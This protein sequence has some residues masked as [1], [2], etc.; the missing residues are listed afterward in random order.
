MQADSLPAEPPGK[1]KRSKEEKKMMFLI[2]I[3]IFHINVEGSRITPPGFVLLL[4]H[5]DVCL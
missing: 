2:K 5:F 1:L 3:A 4:Y